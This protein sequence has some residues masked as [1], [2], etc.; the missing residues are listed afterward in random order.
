MLRPPLFSP[1]RIDIAP[2]FICLAG[3][4]QM[5]L[6]S[7]SQGVEVEVKVVWPSQAVS[8]PKRK[9]QIS[10]SPLALLDSPGRGRRNGEKRAALSQYKYTMTRRASFLSSPAAC[11]ALGGK[12]NTRR[13]CSCFG[14]WRW[15]RKEC[16]GVSLKLCSLSHFDCRCF[17]F[18]SRGAL[19]QQQQPIR[20]VP[21]R[22]Q[23][24]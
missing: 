10:S 22:R 2:R 7:L 3:L 11:G 19:H 8:P 14:G 4:A 12:Q 24:R 6:A 13:T 5:L 20:S 9:C 17:F 23:L 15:G 1:P 21:Q 16:G 18:P